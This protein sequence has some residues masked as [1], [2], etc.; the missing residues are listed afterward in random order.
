MSKKT[1]AP[2]DRHTFSSSRG[3]HVEFFWS[4]LFWSSVGARLAA[5]L[6][7]FQHSRRPNY[8]A[9]A[10]P[11]VSARITHVAKLTTPRGC[12]TII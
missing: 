7:M 5:P 9:H 6:S 10:Q 8:K 12:N 11:K 3:V 4:Y 2:C 1:H